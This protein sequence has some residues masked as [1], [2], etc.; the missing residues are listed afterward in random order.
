[1]EE[2]LIGIGADP[3]NLSLADLLSRE[4]SGDLLPSRITF[5]EREATAFWHSLCRYFQ[6]P[7]TGFGP[8]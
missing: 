1:V 3:A 2:D 6:E 8:R 5:F 4:R 7:D